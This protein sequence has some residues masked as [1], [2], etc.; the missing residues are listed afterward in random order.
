M[1][2][3]KELL[4]KFTR[5]L[6]IPESEGRISL[7][8]FSKFFSENFEF[9]D[10]IEIDKLGYFAYKKVKPVETNSDLY[11]RVLLFSEEKISP[12]NKNLLLFFLPAEFEREAPYIDSFLN[13]SFDKPLITSETIDVSDLVLSPSNNEMISLIESKVEKLFS[14]GK[15]HKSSDINEQEFILPSGEEEILF[16]TGLPIEPAAKVDDIEMVSEPDA[17]IIADEQNVINTFDDYELVEPDKNLSLEESKIENEQE[18]KWGMDELDLQDY[19]EM[20][21]EEESAPTLDGYTEVKDLF[22][23]KTSAAESQ[24]VL[25][26]LEKSPVNST[27]SSP[28]KNAKIKLVLVLIAVIIVTIAAGVYFNYDLIKNVIFKN[29]SNLTQTVAAQ[30]KIEPNVIARTFEIPVTYPYKIEEEVLGKIPDSLIISASVFNSNQTFITEAKNNTEMIPTP[31]DEL[32][33]V[34]QNIYRRGSEFLVQV[35]SWK[36]KSKA[37]SELNKFI[38][39]GFHAELIED[40]SREIG[41]YRRLMVGGFKSLEEANNFL[42]KNK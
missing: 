30:K 37:E 35:S 8:I 42:N 14:E 13:L 23:G 32:V 40:Y 12:Q 3:H 20:P 1:I 16:D 26:D 4:E 34:Q 41:K 21:N 18:V 29:E 9:G 28:K 11:L 5:R 19:T 15:I 6:G 25:A 33:K 38:E 10:E 36:S 24:Q 22:L 2:N 7:E 17:Q 31:G 39:N 27:A